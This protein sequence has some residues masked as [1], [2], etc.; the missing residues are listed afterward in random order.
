M[1]IVNS[2]N[3]VKVKFNVV[4]SDNLNNLLQQVPS[5][6]KSWSY[7]EKFIDTIQYIANCYSYILPVNEEFNNIQFAEYIKEHYS[8]EN[9][10]N[11]YVYDF[12]MEL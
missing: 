2:Y 6:M 12:L 10:R 4:Y 1:K 8:L 7:A 9:E 3:G 11:N 5:H